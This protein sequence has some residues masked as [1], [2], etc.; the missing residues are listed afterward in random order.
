MDVLCLLEIISLFVERSEEY[1]LPY[2]HVHIALIGYSS[3]ALFISGIVCENAV[4]IGIV[5]NANDRANDKI[6]VFIF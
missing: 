4:R 3:D 6:V 1:V 2:L 5:G